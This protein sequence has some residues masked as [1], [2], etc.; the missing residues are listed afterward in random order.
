M[1]LVGRHPS[2]PLT[3]RD[4]NSHEAVPLQ[5]LLWSPTGRPFGLSGG[6]SVTYEGDHTGQIY[7]TF[8][9]VSHGVKLQS[10]TGSDTYTQLA[11]VQLCTF[12]IP[13]R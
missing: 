4:Q 11:A 12:V 2:P 1:S 9:F 6:G 7:G 8:P 5:F 10:G 3:T 13:H